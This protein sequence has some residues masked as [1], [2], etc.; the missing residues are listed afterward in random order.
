MLSDLQDSFQFFDR[1]NIGLVSQ[2]SFESIIYNFGFNRISIKEKNDE[3]TKHDPKYADRTGFDF[4][5]LKYVVSYRWNKGS[6]A[7]LE[8]KAAFKVFDKRDKN[9]IGIAEFKQVFAD[10][11]EC[12]VSDQ[13]LQELMQ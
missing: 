6:G 10:Y 8:A 7:A 5:Y 13:D 11:L 2:K 3:L 9:I 1:D 4:N 12:T